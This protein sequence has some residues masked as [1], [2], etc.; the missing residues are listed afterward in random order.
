MTKA[1]ELQL[2]SFAT[3]HEISAQYRIPVDVLR[4]AW[5]EP[6]APCPIE[7]LPNGV[8]W[9]PCV[10]VEAWFN[11]RPPVDLAKRRQRTAA[12][13]AALARLRKA[14]KMK[15]LSYRRIVPAVLDVKAPTGEQRSRV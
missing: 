8:L 15:G 1:L 9:Y 13:T 7:I 4:K 12:A 5:K 11:S 14:A 6:G 2:T 10:P 3:I